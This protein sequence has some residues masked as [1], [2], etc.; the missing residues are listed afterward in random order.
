MSAIPTVT[1][2]TSS[3]PPPQ[4]M[5]IQSLGQQEFI[6]IL[7]AQLTSQDPMNPQKDT[8][9]V[10]QMAQFSQL[11][12]SKTLT[13]E[14]TSLRQQQDFL[15]AN[16]LIGRQIQVADGD[17]QFIGTVTG[18]EMSKGSPLIA[19]GEKTFA[20]NEVVRVGAPA[21]GHGYAN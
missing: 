21:S 2:S 17:A 9:F 10:A 14:L 8:E 13:A 6:K 18:V 12:S 19:V 7:V 20:L 1:N 3:A 4:R 5:P 15:S 11:E 16:S